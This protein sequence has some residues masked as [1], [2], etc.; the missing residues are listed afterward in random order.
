MDDVRA[1]RLQASRIVNL[2]L[3]R[4]VVVVDDVDHLDAMIA[5]AVERALAML[6]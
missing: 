6:S 3:K 4:A 1:G 5:S 2:D